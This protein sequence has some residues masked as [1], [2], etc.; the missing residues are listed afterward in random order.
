MIKPINVTS[1][2]L[3]TQV[4]HAIM[5]GA[6]DTAFAQTRLLVKRV[7]LEK[8]LSEAAKRKAKQSVSCINRNVGRKLVKAV[9]VAS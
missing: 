2:A 4:V 5:C 3:F 7:R 9:T 8:L 6:E 1:G